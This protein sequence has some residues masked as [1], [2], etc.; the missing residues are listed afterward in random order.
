MSRKFQDTLAGLTVAIRRLSDPSTLTSK[1][2][3]TTE[4]EY[5]SNLRLFVESMA[6]SYSYFKFSG[7]VIDELVSR[8]NFIIADRLLPADAKFED[9]S[10]V[11]DAAD[12]RLI[13]WL[14]I[15]ASN[16]LKHYDVTSEN[17]EYRNLVRR[18]LRAWKA[19]EKETKKRSD[20]SEVGDL[21]DIHAAI[22]EM[23]D[24]S[25]LNGQPISRSVPKLVHLVWKLTGGKIERRDLVEIISEILGVHENLLVAD[26][27]TDKN[28][29]NERGP[30]AI[31]ISDPD[32]VSPDIRHD[33][34]AE[35]ERLLERLDKENDRR[36]FL[37]L[38]HRF[39]LD[40]TFAMIENKTLIPIS[41]QEFLF[42]T[43][44]ESRLYEAIRACSEVPDAQVISA[45]REK[46]AELLNEWGMRCEA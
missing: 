10:L 20:Y 46:T 23:I 1:Q 11:R 42:R 37:L 8:M 29:E 45:F 33:I 2:R 32:R 4:K 35:A 41:T 9:G 31:M 16:L 5:I 6:L 34:G 22:L 43:K 14:K 30:K 7:T 25:E 13:G 38:C 12:A 40:M 17:K 24:P 39:I 21:K 18:V 26:S 27:E 19:L 36:L 3:A 15:T 44:I 28:D